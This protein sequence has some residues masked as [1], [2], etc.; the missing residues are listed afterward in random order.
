M[1]PIP[2][3]SF[4]YFTVALVA[5][6]QFP[7]SYTMHHVNLGLGIGINEFIVVAGIPLLLAYLLSFDMRAL[8]AF[9]KPKRTSWL[10]LALFALGLVIVIDYLTAGSDAVIPMP[11]RHRIVMDGIMSVSSPGEF[12]YKFVLLCIVPGVCEEIFFRGYCQTSFAHHKGNVYAVLVTGVLF[13]LLH[14]N[15]YHI[16]LYFLLGCALS[17]IYAV[18]RTLWIPIALHLFN[19]AWTF[20]NHT[21]GTTLPW[22]DASLTTNA[23]VLIIG[24]ALTVAGGAWYY[25]TR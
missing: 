19:N 3:P 4:V 2:Y 21:F 1:P 14:G 17:W 24:I 25:R 22:R 16:H 5:L 20:T 13:A 15:V 18:S 12:A 11:E 7:A 10:P 8:F 6:M 23:A 9:P